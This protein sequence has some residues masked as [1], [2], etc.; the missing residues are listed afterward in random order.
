MLKWIVI[1]IFASKVI[2]DA[3]I[4]HL[5]DV[6]A[7]KELPESVRDVY[8]EADYKRWQ[9]YHADKRKFNTIK[10]IIMTVIN[11]GFLVGNVYAF[12]FN[13]M[14]GSLY[15]QYLLTMLVFEGFY[16]IVDIPFSH[17]ATFTIEEKYGMNKTT[18]ATFIK[19]TIINFVFE[20]AITIFLFTVIM[21]AF[22]WFGNLGILIACAAIAVFMI[23]MQMFSK[24][25]M[26]AF[27]KF[28]P[29]EEGSL[30][31]KLMELCEKYN[32]SVKEISVVDFSKRTTK[33]NAF[34]SGLGKR[35]SIGLAD[36]LVERYSEDQIVAVFA[37]E[38]GHAKFKHMPI[39]VACN[40]LNICVTICMFGLILN[41]PELFKVFGFEDVNYYFLF[42]L[43]TIT[44]PLSTA[45]SLLLN[46]ISRKC[47]FQADALAAREGYGE[48]I[49]SSLKQ[50]NKEALS[51]LNPHPVVVALEHNHPTLAQRI[52]AIRK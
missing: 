50:L 2:F 49:I 28:T 51:D 48:D 52:E 47:E 4:D 23:L 44:W 22:G 18:K 13:K 37:H 31:T 45:I 20:F 17:Y 9:A 19:D 3:Y 29:L 26:R 30:R 43:V 27:N 24:V 35:K 46:Y 12:I 40:I 38:F 5:R 21:F 15:V 36:N 11:I 10:S 42:T 1:A 7:K 6:A 25:F 8:D 33:A 32:T 34:C 39:L 41:F 14:P 16:A